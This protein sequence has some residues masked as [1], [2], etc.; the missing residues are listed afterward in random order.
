MLLLDEFRFMDAS[1][2]DVRASEARTRPAVKRAKCFIG[3]PPLVFMLSRPVASVILSPS[4]TFVIPS[5]S[6]TLSSRAQRGICFRRFERL[7]EG[8]ALAL[9]T[10]PEQIPRRFAPRDD[11]TAPRD[12]RDKAI[13]PGAGPPAVA[14]SGTGGDRPEC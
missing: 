11:R 6:P 10:T 9:P 3:E 8:S 4:P 1:A 13:A 5:P 2:G 12:D 14:V 7:R